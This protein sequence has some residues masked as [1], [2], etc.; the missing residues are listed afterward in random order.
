MKPLSAPFSAFHFDLAK[1]AQPS[2]DMQ[3]SRTERLAALKSCEAAAHTDYDPDA[4][5][6][7]NIW[8]PLKSAMGIEALAEGDP[9]FKDGR[10]VEALQAYQK[11]VGMEPLNQPVQARLRAAKKALGFPGG[12]R[13][14]LDLPI[15][16]EGI[17]NTMVFWFELQM[18][19]EDEDADADEEEDEGDELGLK[20]GKISTSPLLAEGGG[21]RAGGHWL[22]ACQVLEEV[23]VAKGEAIPLEGLIGEAGADVRFSIERNKVA[24]PAYHERRTAVPPVDPLWV[25]SQQEAQQ[26]MEKIEQL[27]VSSAEGHQQA[28]EAAAAIAVDPGRG[29]PEAIDPQRANVF[30]LSFHH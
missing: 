30:A 19:K 7:E 5:D 21:T 12:E 9:A 3:G 28:A 27:V 23:R 15:V 6:P 8:G 1:V 4:P 22:Q 11:A 24:A 13:V 26:K 2:A 14:A 18:D 10:M 25:R 20:M 29:G 17:A 16:E